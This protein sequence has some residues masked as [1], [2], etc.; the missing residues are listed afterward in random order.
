MGYTLPSSSEPNAS[1]PADQARMLM[2]QKQSIESELEAQFSI[3]KANNTDLHTPLVDREGFPRDDID[4]WA[5]RNARVRII[6]LR[7]DLSAV[8]NSIGKAL[9]GVFDPSLEPSS[10]R[11]GAS[12]AGAGND[13]ADLTPFAK[14][15]SVA[16]S[17]PA[18]EAG[19]KPQDLIVK[20]GHLT[21]KASPSLQAVAE[22]VNENENRHI[23]IRILRSGQTQH[24]TLT[25]KGGWGG[26]GLL[27]C[28][29][30]PYSTP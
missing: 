28:H 27:G 19:L 11:S 13:E 18:S 7:N 15:N 26:R 5:V 22:V 24:L 9:E 30:V 3:L 14:V 16:P 10:A 1:S 8:M 29:I 25:P 2:E 21:S 6:E 12:G 23:V 4:V 17:S 20:F